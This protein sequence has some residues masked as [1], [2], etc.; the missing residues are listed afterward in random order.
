M[1]QINR[2]TF[3][4]T[5]LVAP[6][7]DRGNSRLSPTAAA[8]AHTPT[9]SRNPSASTA[10]PSRHSSVTTWHKLTPGAPEPVPPEPVPPESVPP[11]PV[12]PEPVPPEPEPASGASS[13]GA[14][15]PGASELPVPTDEPTAAGIAAP[16]R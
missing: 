16:T 2:M 7:L 14:A 8:S 9:S 13:G 15:G 5:Y 10:T 4:L 3:Q 6:S 11:E 1:P 12:P